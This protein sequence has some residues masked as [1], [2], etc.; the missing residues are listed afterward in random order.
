M[1]TLGAIIKNIAFLT[2]LSFSFISPLLLCLLICWWM[3][4]SLGIGE[5]IFI[6][7]FF[8]GLGGSFTV[9]YKLYLSVTGHQKK[10]KKKNKVSFNR[11][12]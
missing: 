10:E 9:A 8:F 7:G 3:S 4:T 12:H 2:Q 6:P 5:W 11:H 1:K